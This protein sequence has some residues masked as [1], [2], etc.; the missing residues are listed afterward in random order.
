MRCKGITSNK[1]SRKLSI[2]KTFVNFIRQRMDLGASSSA[3]VIRAEARVAA[4][5]GALASEFSSS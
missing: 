5:L 4:A 2:A 1:T 3:D